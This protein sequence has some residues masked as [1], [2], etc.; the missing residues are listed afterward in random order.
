MLNLNSKNVQSHLTHSA[1]KLAERAGIEPAVD[2]FSC[3]LPVLKTG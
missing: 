3:L 1:N 2:S